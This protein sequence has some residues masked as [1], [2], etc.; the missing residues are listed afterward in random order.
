MK[1]L[2]SDQTRRIFRDFLRGVPI[3]KIMLKYSID[4]EQLYFIGETYRRRKHP[5]DVGGSGLKADDPLV[6]TADTGS[7]ATE[8]PIQLHS[9]KDLRDAESVEATS[10]V[11][12]AVETKDDKPKTKKILT[13]P[14]AEKPEGEKPPT[15]A[16][17]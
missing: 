12:K 11:E 10:P 5:N 8:N 14:P 4:R 9:P 13:T 17:S 15:P 7:Q 16:K 2:T 6:S 3:E 1:Q